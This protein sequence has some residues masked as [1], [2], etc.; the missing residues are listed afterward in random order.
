MTDDER[1]RET[2]P[3]DT[4]PSE[5]M[6]PLTEQRFRA[7]LHE[8]VTQG[9]GAKILEMYELMKVHGPRIDALDDRLADHERRIAAI[10]R[11]IGDKVRGS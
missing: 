1:E 2:I 4:D 3:P 5:G 10:E 7:I 11:M 9:I 6:A 8:V